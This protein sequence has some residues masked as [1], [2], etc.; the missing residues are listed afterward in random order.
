MPT[1][2]GSGSSR[3]LVVASASSH[4][5]SNALQ[6]S[7][8]PGIASADEDTILTTYQKS[9][10]TGYCSVGNAD[11]ERDDYRLDDDWALI[12]EE[13]I[14]RQRIDVKDLLS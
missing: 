1:S 4:P 12:P 3:R 8:I 10:F 14:C 13:E 9:F 7:A 2:T 11:L 5:R 6:P